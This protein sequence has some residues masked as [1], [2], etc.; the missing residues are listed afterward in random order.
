MRQLLMM[1]FVAASVA[2]AARAD[3]IEDGLT[4]KADACIHDQAARVTG[5]SQTLN[6]A[7]GFLIDDLC[8]VQIQ[9]AETYASSARM[10]ADWRAAPIRTSIPVGVG[11]RPLNDFEKRLVEDA[12]RTSDQL[13]QVTINPETGELNAPPGFAA[14]LNPSSLLTSALRVGLSPHARFKAV[15]AEAVLAARG[16]G[17]AARSAGQH[18]RTRALAT[19]K[20]ATSGQPK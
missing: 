8:A 14:P 15:A 9:H 4:K 2:G 6:E 12:S 1:A 13:A 3:A 18:P 17:P 16:A 19:P 11:G 20:D 5:L 7:V 10:L